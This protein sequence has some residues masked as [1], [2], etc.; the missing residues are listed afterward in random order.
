MFVHIFTYST[1]IH[2]YVH[3]YIVIKDE[4]YAKKP[5]KGLGKIN[6]NRFNCSL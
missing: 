4:K 5:F 1:Y 2:V 6:K 3:I